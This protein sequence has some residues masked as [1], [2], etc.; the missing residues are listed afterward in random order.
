MFAIPNGGLRNASVAAK[1]KA[2]GVK[3][4]ISDIFL[5]IARGVYHGLFIEMKR[6]KPRGVPTKEQEAFFSHLDSAG[7]AYAVCYGWQAAVAALSRYLSL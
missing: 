7:Y 6:P 3:P 1:L 2:E 4:G 5:P